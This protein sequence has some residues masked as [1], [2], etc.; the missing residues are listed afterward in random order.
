M[1]MKFQN[2]LLLLNIVTVL[3]IL[4]ITLLPSNALR[5]ALGLPFVLFF[6]GYLLTV[7]L[8]P[9]RSTLD[10]IERVA[11]SFG[12][13]IVVVSLV[14]LI[15]NYTPWGIKLYPI[16]ISLAFFIVVISIVAWYRRRK[17]AQVQGF[18][19]S[20]R[21]D[22]ASWRAQN[23]VDRVLTIILVVAI[24]GAIG[25]LGYVIATPK[26]GEKF[27]EFYILGPEGQAIE[28]PKEMKVGEQGRVMVGI[29]NQEQ[30]AVTYWLKV[31]LDGV[32]QSQMGPIELVHGENWTEIVG[33]APHRAGDEQK[34][35]FLLYRNGESKPHRELHLW[36]NVKER[37]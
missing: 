10:G 2:D 3:L 37:E 1:R 7:A 13:S 21:L 19:I 9:R 36:I 23:L 4:I 18:T 17:L 29:I 11:L 32:S 6:P 14:G 22:L 35:E 31:Q 8:F 16:L 30:E 26:V 12:L 25:T 27:T 33:F 15:L 5:I 24:L 34:V 28:Y 20:F